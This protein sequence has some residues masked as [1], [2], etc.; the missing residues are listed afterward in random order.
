MT[1]SHSAQNG[2]KK[3][4]HVHTKPTPPTL[5]AS[6]VPLNATPSEKGKLRG[7]RN[8]KIKKKEEKGETEEVGA[9]TWDQLGDG[10]PRKK[11]QTPS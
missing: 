6:L 7:K 3:K 4:N 9:P 5:A 8:R 11:Q 2:R 10:S 1:I